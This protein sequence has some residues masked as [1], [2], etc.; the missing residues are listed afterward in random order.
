MEFNVE[1]I[2]N[3]KDGYSFGKEL[4]KYIKGKNGFDF[5]FNER[6]IDVNNSQLQNIIDKEEVTLGNAIIINYISKKN[7]S[8]INKNLNQE[9]IQDLYPYIK[10]LFLSLMKIEKL[11]EFFIN[12]FVI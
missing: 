7:N 6:K 4:N 5:Y 8:N 10:S 9:I 12:Y 3:F 11:K 2:F 1:M